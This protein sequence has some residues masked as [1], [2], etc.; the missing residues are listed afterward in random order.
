[1]PRR[2]RVGRVVS[3]LAAFALVAAPAARAQDPTRVV[4]TRAQIEAAGW[5]NLGEM[6]TGATGWHRSTLDAVSFFAT[7]DGMPPGAVAPGE[8]EYLVVVDGQRIAVDV[9]GAKL[10][11]LLPISPAQIESVTVTRVP[12]LAAGTIASR[13]VVEFHTRRGHPGPAIAG[14]WHSGNVIGD[15]GPYAFTP[16]TTENVDRLGPYNYTVAGVGAAGWDVAAG[17]RQGSSHTTHPG[18]RRRFDPVLFEQLGVHKWAPYDVVHARAGARLLGGRHDVVGGRGWVNGPLF[19]PLAGVEQWMRGAVE[20]LGGAGSVATGAGTVGYQLSHSA[21]D[22]RELPSPFPFVAAHSRRRTSG[23][24]DVG[25]G[26]NGG[27]HARLGAAATRWSLDR[28][29]TAA[30][31]T[32]AT[33]FANFAA[34]IGRSTNEVSGALARSSGGRVVGKSVVATR[35]VADSLTVLSAALSYVQHAT[36]D[37]GTWIDRVLVGLDTSRRQRDSRAWADLGVARRLRGGWMAELGARAG[38]LDDVHLLALDAQSAG[39]PTTAGVAEVRAGL[40]LPM[41]VKLP[42]ARF[43]YRYAT[44]FSGDRE[45]REALRATPSHSFDGQL[46]GA[47]A[48]DLRLGAFL[49]VASR[50]R[51]AALRGGPATPLTLPAVS[52]LDASAEKWFWRHR[53]RTQL[54]V[55]NLLNQPERY[56]PL[57]ADFPLRAHLTVALALPPL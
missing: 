24:L 10:L 35:V 28:D 34:A 48:P 4:I 14:A 29:G 41:T 31:R 53:V 2:A 32:D 11:E 5:F 54:L 33:L 42:V 22:V 6:L 38:V 50:A 19:L 21:I 1:M 23:V 57:G 26:D 8:P 46:V 7:A 27:R 18:I 3:G 44:T 52:R 39:A 47:V 40:S 43:A 37:D 49:Y 25:V 56:H 55:R 16:L 30:A 15:P 45:L 13:G 9:L 17:A 51:W 36:G 20:H 12:R